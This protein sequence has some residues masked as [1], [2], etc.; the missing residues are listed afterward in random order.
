MPLFY[1][2]DARRHNGSGSPTRLSR[3]YAA[4]LATA[5]NEADAPPQAT[6]CAEMPDRA[7]QCTNVNAT[8]SGPLGRPN[9]FNSP[10]RLSRAS[11]AALAVP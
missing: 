11:G 4:A 2:A 6:T 3:S 9:R 8:V 7:P 1:R 10:A 5:H